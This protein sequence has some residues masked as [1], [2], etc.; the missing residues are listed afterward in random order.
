MPNRKKGW[1]FLRIED[2]D[3]ELITLI[4]NDQL[5]HLEFGYGS[6][7]RVHEWSFNSPEEAK[8]AKAIILKFCP[9]ARDKF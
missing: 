5:K 4:N 3:K 6:Y 1:I 2:E 8:E 9:N 7:I